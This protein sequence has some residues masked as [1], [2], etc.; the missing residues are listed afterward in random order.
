MVLIVVILEI[1]ADDCFLIDGFE[2]KVK[3]KECKILRGR[4]SY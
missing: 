2:E 4:I 1:N 3:N